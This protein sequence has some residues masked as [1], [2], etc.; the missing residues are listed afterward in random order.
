MNKYNLG[1]Q[2]VVNGIYVSKSGEQKNN[3]KIE[4]GLVLCVF[5]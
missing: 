2:K 1:K 3:K 4:N 5:T